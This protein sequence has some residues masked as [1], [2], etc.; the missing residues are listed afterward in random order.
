MPLILLQFF[1]IFEYEKDH[2]SSLHFIYTYQFPFLFSGKIKNEFWSCACCTQFCH[3]GKQNRSSRPGKCAGNNKIDR[4]T[5]RK[6]Q[7]FS[8]KYCFHRTESKKYFSTRGK[9]ICK[10]DRSKKSFFKNKTDERQH[11]GEQPRCCS[12]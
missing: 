7:V 12:S 10:T 6:F 11:A 9:T 1:L 5:R 4:R 3:A 2:L 8:R